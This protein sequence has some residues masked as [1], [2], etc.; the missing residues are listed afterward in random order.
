M[1]H[2]VYDKNKKLVFEGEPDEVYEYFLEL[3]S[4]NDK[5]NKVKYE[6]YLKYKKK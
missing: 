6:N 3:M 5:D 4:G 2:K 1:A